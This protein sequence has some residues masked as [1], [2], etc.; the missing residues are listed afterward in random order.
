MTALAC[1]G[2]MAGC[3]SLGLQ[4][5]ERGTES[6]LA[7][8]APPTPE[9]AVEMFQDE[10]N[11]DN[12]Y[13]GAVLLTQAWF[14]SENEAYIELFRDYLLND[15]D[16]SIRAVCARGLGNHA[17]SSYAPA[18]AT[19]LRDDPDEEVRE[20]AARALQR[21][22]NPA[23]VRT[24]VEASREPDPRNI[25]MASENAAQVRVEAVVALGQYE[26][27][28]VVDALIS[29]LD[30]SSLVVH[31]AAIRSLRILTGQDFGDD[32]TAWLR[33]RQTTK[34]MFLAGEVYEYPVFTRS[35]LWW[36]YV[37]LVPPPPN[38]E[39]ARPAGGEPESVDGTLSAGQ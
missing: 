15:P 25:S 1:V 3:E 11:S 19:A 4:E 28:Y 13:K 27:P 7:Y 8:F 16:P 17:D 22:H 6:I 23:V 2:A 24:L 38:E 31:R 18:L 10:D 36:E 29:A 32:P 12:R 39:P 30:D 35:K 14:V 37:P 5:P 20:E 34:D 9:E 26:E 33:W 21:I